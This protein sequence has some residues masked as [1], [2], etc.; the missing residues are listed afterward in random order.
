[1]ESEVLAHTG[2][3]A[4]QQPENRRALPPKYVP[5]RVSVKRRA[6]EYSISV[7]GTPWLSVYTCPQFG[8][9]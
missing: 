3:Q 1:V 4:M 9:V 7:T 8:Q 5:V 2:R 6:S